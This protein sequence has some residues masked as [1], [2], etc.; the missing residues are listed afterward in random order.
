MVLYGNISFS[1]MQVMTKWM[2]HIT[3]DNIT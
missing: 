3:Y 2:L 1:P